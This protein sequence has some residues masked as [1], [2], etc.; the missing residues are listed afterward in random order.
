MTHPSRLQSSGSVIPW[1]CTPP[2]GQS[3]W[4]FFFPLTFPII[5]SYLLRM[6][7]QR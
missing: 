4:R 1:A 6:T 5:L 7:S 2:V 3:N